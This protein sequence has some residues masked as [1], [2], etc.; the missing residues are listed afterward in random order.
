[1]AE[2]MN[3]GTH[4][5]KKDPTYRSHIFRYRFARGWIEPGWTVVDGAC[6]TG[7]GSAILSDIASKVTGIDRNAD[8]IKTAN[9]DHYSENID[10]IQRDLDDIENWNIQVDAWVTIETIEHLKD[11][12]KYA[13]MIKRKTRSRIILTCPIVPTKATNPHHLHDIAVE[14]INAWFG[15]EYWFMVHHALQG[16]Y[17]MTVFSNE[18]SDKNL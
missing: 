12:K 2:F 9:S 15:D 4:P 18:F 6:G 17:I 14:D 5:N 13:E 11:P 1:M 10:F 16:P 8:C 3:F 7:Y